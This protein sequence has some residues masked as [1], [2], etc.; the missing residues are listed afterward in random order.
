MPIVDS[1]AY[2]FCSWNVILSGSWSSGATDF[3]FYLVL[4]VYDPLTSVTQ[5]SIYFNTN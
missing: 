4:L 3:L 1:F 2:S 5:Y